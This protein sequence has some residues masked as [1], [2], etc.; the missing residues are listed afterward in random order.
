MSGIGGVDQDRK[1]VHGLF[2]KAV[3]RTS[4]VRRRTQL[5]RLRVGAVVYEYSSIFGRHNIERHAGR[6]RT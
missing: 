5:T 1:D 6:G 2:D 4:C 3:D